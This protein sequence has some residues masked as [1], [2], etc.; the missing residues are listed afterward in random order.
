MGEEEEVQ[1]ETPREG[2]YRLMSTKGEGVYTPFAFRSLECALYHLGVAHTIVDLLG[3]GGDMVLK[4]YRDGQWVDMPE[5][6]AEEL[7]A[8]SYDIKEVL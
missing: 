4:Q 8:Q 6:F 3:S 5:G 2:D 7:E 1:T